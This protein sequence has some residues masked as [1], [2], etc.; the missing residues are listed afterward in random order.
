MHKPRAFDTRCHAYFCRYPSQCIQ[1][2]PWPGPVLRR[3]WMS[4][5][6]IPYGPLNYMLPQGQSRRPYLPPA[7][8]EFTHIIRYAN[9]HVNFTTGNYS[10]SRLID[11]ALSQR[12]PLHTVNHRQLPYRY[13]YGTSTNTYC[14]MRPYR[15][16]PYVRHR[17]L[18]KAHLAQSLRDTHV[19]GLKEA[20]SQSGGGGDQ[21]PPTQGTP[22]LRLG[23]RG[24]Q[25][26]PSP[27]F[28]KWRI[29]CTSFTLTH[30]RDS[31]R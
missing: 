8:S 29:G 21:A 18:L 7:S 1:L 20:T 13:R 2:S 17:Y 14:G 23:G 9:S 26:P 28:T 15:M 25:H 27:K 31:Q 11:L 30:T 22:V 24:T 10:L 19:H 5:L 16:L 12:L 3:I 6:A 4:A